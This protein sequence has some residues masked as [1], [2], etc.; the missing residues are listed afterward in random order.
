M[1]ASE[2]LTSPETYLSLL[3]LTI[4]EIVLGI[5]N[6]IFISILTGRLPPED[7]ARGRNIG[8]LGA[9]V[10]RI[11]LLM[12]ISWLASLTT[13]LFE[14]F[15]MAFSGKSLILLAGGLFLIAKATHEVHDKLEGDEQ[16]AA[17]EA[18]SSGRT[19]AKVI[20]Q[21]M[22]LDLVFSIDS[23]IT[24]VGMSQQLSI[25]VA[26]NVIALAVMLASSS[27]IAGFVEKHPSIKM[28]ALS[29]LMMIGFVLVAEGFSFHIP[30]GYIYFAMGFSIFVEVLNLK[31]SAR[32]KPVALHKV[33]RE[34][35]S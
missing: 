25:M 3:T 22:I 16:T 12:M 18:A 6:I 19:F 23:V 5:D 15:G 17:E 35:A 10:T 34:P 31:S 20:V 29:F 2:F 1:L 7:R 14:V 28:L 30:K 32:S 24:A 8:L 27:F 13:P 4:M 11:V 33:P 26:A 9:L 21:I